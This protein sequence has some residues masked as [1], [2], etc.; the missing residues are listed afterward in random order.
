MFTSWKRG[1]GRVGDRDADVKEISQKQTEK[2]INT[3]KTVHQARV[4]GLL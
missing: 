1:E 2:R 4:P 3:Q